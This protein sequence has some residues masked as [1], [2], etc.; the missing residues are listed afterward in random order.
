ME[1]LRHLIN[2]LP[3]FIFISLFS[4]I[5]SCSS[6]KPT[7]QNPPTTLSEGPF[8]G[9]GF[10]NG[11]ADQNSISIWTRLTK[12]PEGKMDGAKFIELTND[13]HQELRKSKDQ[14]L[15]HS[16]QIPAGKSLEEMIGACPG[17]PGE[18]RLTYFPKKD[19]SNRKIIDWS[20][21]DSQKDFTI[22]WK[23]NGL[24]ANTK[25]QVILEARSATNTKVS[26]SFN[27]E[28]VTA[29]YPTEEENIQFVIVT[30][31]DFIRRDDPKN[32][33]KIYPAMAKLKPDFYVHAGD[34]EYYDKPR[35]YAMTEA[36]MY[37]KWNRLFALPFQRD[38]FRSTTT[39]FIKDDH[40]ALANDTYPGMTYGTVDYERGLE[41]F[42]QEQFPS[43]DQ[44][45]KTIRWGK[46]LQI[47]IVEGRNFRSKNTDPDGPDK[48]IWGK[49]Q[50]EWFYRTVKESKATFKILMTS[51]P[52][53]GP[54][55][56]NKS[57]NYSNSNFKHEGDEIRA[58]LNQQNNF[59]ICNGDRHWQYVTHPAG[60]N[61]WEFSAGAG[62][63]AHAGGWKQSD[64]RPEHQFL[65]VKGGFLSGKVSQKG[66]YPTLI[67]KHHD[68]EGKV[69]HQEVFTVDSKQ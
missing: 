18:V 55:R 22:Q 6:L 26:H 24:L 60:T 13:Q 53:L 45:Y 68:V 48:T 4:L 1:N 37:F 36:L 16:S 66:G 51:T 62:A 65:R 46:D 56:K 38:F 25:Y 2:T 30:C 41:I 57:D 32:G 7:Q 20:P 31:H 47:W 15:L 8:F 17:A 11:W 43:N 52:I 58:F 69:V 50:K 12:T 23:L 21:V 5:S 9:N 54:D 42:D 14:N 29:P 59:F 49:T 33:H 63:D 64:K 35:P 39:Y 34:I 28:F 3:P 61:L 44:L 67:F 19:K 10:R 40:D 27:G